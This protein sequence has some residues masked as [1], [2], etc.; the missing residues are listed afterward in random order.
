MILPVA[1][2]FFAVPLHAQ[3]PRAKGAEDDAKKA[4]DQEV[5]T[6]LEAFQKAFRGTDGERAGAVKALGKVRD[7]RVIAALST[8]LADPAPAV[9]VE[10]AKALGGYAK[11]PAA[12]RAVTSALPA[13]K[14][15]PTVRIA[16]FDALGDIRD[17]GVSATVIEHFDDLDVSVS[18]AAMR[19]AGNIRNP[20]FVKELIDFL[21]DRVGGSASAKAATF[22]EARLRRT[23]LQLA[24]H[25]ALHAITGEKFREVKEWKDWWK[26]DGAKLTAKLQKEE[27]EELERLAQKR[28]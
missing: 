3:G 5:Q 7:G 26:S 22:E 9:R 23:Q 2:V 11:D 20:A 24:A 25:G 27:R 28:P 15:Q 13:S 10:A 16:Y 19:A 4:H 17:W 14:K 21:D 8:A 6:A 1:L 12:S 18:R